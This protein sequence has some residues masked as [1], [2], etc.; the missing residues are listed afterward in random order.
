MLNIFLNVCD[1]HFKIF[2]Q[3]TVCH[4]LVFSRDN[5]LRAIENLMKKKGRFDYILLET[6]GLAD[7]GAVASMFWVDAE[8]GVDIYLDG[9]ITVLD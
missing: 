2:R 4:V 9:I 3:S 1:D 6:T 7:P 8:L 5:G